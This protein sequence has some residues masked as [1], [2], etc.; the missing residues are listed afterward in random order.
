MKCCRIRLTTLVRL[1]ANCAGSVYLLVVAT[2][3]I[4]LCDLAADVLGVA[5]QVTDAGD[6][7]PLEGALIGL[8]LLSNGE[9]IAGFEPLTPGGAP[10]LAPTPSDGKFDVPLLYGPTVECRKDGQ[11]FSPTPN[12]VEVIVNHDGC[13]TRTTIDINADTVVDPNIPPPGT[14]RDGFTIQ[15]K[16]PI[17]VPACATP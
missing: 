2:S 5:G 17:A 16:N 4:P 7:T 6:G 8:K 14:P 11:T 9:V 3:C 1:F 15:L 10:Q 12:Q 13:E